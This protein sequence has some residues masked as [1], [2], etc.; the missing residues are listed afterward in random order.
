M[1]KWL[2]IL[3]VILSF[4]VI[5]AIL[6]LILKACNIANI[7]T[8]KSLIAKSGKYGYIIYTLLLVL[9][10]VVFC[11]V[12]LL[13]TTMAILGIALF[14]SKIAFITN[15][16]AVFI[17]TTTLFFIGDIFG[18]KFAT[19]LIGKKSLE[20]TQAAIDHKSKFWLPILFITPGIPDEAICLVAGMTKIK[21]WYIILISMIYHTI[22]IGIF[23]FF[24]S[25]VISW[26]TLTILDWIVLINVILIDLYF[27]FK[28]EKFLENKT[29]NK[30]K[31][32][33]K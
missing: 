10:L 33:K 20:E 17:S 23:C 32:T 5:S 27:L 12:P 16:I 31:T 21:Y 2:K 1:K 18:E 6:F 28:I 7:N 22:E 9:V 13:N 8:I 15:I 24:G 19:R 30:Q 11:F 4:A 29:K 14:G 26:S 3:V 25:S